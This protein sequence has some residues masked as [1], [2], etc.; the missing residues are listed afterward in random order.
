M[1]CKGNVPSEYGYKGKGLMGQ[2]ERRG[3]V[4]E[5]G[6]TAASSQESAQGL[7][8]SSKPSAESRDHMLC[9]VLSRIGSPYIST[10]SIPHGSGNTLAST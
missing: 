2:I 1:D 5:V 6:E 4:R 7:K 3:R 9:Q 8:M 10:G